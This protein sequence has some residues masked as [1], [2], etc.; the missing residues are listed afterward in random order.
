VL[1]ATRV[2]SEI[3]LAKSEVVPVRQIVQE[4]LAHLA[5]GDVESYTIRLQV[6]EQVTAWT[7]P[8]LLRQVL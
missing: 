5:P 4:E 3:P 1:E 8:Q 6:P 2:V 7:D